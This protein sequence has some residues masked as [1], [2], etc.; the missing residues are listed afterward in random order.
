MLNTY[1]YPRGK[2]ADYDDL[3]DIYK[4]LTRNAPGKMLENRKLLCKTSW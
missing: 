2:T 1:V 3:H 4:S